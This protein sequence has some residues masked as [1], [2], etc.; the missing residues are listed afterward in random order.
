[1]QSPPGPTRTWGPL[2]GAARASACEPS[3]NWAS[4]GPILGSGEEGRVSSVG[5]A[6]FLRAHD[7]AGR[8]APALVMIAAKACGHQPLQWGRSTRRLRIVHGAK[9]WGKGIGTV[10]CAVAHPTL[11]NQELT[12]NTVAADRC[13]RQTQSGGDAGGDKP[14]HYGRLFR[15]D[16]ARGGL[17]ARP[18]NAPTLNAIIHEAALHPRSMKTDSRGSLFSR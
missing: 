8:R 4:S 16:V 6:R 17:Y 10:G 13:A 2:R 5:W 15:S 11:R 7:Q 9:R 12:R 14:C 3:P 18:P 1:M